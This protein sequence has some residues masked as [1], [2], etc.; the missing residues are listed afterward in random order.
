MEKKVLALIG[1]GFAIYQATAF[2]TILSLENSKEDC[3]NSVLESGELHIRATAFGTGFIEAKQA[4]KN[5]EIQCKK[6]EKKSNFISSI[7]GLDQ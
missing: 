6:M 5:A 3:I 1:L 4:E 7:L 2:A